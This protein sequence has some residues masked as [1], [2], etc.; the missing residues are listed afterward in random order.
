[1]TEQPDLPS[2]SNSNPLFEPTPMS[3]VTV[4]PQPSPTH[5]RKA[6][7]LPTDAPAW[8]VSLHENLSATFK[9]ELQMLKT[10]LQ[11]TNARVDKIMQDTT[12][13]QATITDI[14]H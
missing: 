14:A 11:F 2:T 5:K 13:I 6:R 1:M 4:P 7:T 8:A 9:E 10:D 12:V 3:I